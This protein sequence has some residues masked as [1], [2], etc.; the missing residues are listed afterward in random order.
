MDHYATQRRVSPSR[1][2]GGSTTHSSPRRGIHIDE[3]SRAATGVWYYRVD[4]AVYADHCAHS[5]NDD[6]N[7]HM[8]S[9]SEDSEF[10]GYASPKSFGAASELDV[11][12]QYYS[13]LRRYNDFL[14]LYDQVKVYV[15]TQEPVPEYLANHNS[16][17]GALPPFPEKEFLS[18]SVFGMLWRMSPSNHVLEDRRA[19]FQAFLQWVEQH[20]IARRAPAYAAFLG[21]PP[22]CQNGYVSLKEY[23]S[24]N[25]LSS[26]RQLAKDKQE[27]TRRYTMDAENLADL[28]ESTKPTGNAKTLRAVPETSAKPPHAAVYAFLGKRRRRARTNK[29]TSKPNATPQQPPLTTTELQHEHD[30]S[31]LAKRDIAQVGSNRPSLKKSKSF[32]HSLDAVLVSAS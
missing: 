7:H 25:W 13:V 24:P 11:H 20:P 31:A 26:L 12:S 16:N 28:L 6:S 2:S 15:A 29:N 8:H 14:H 21:R 22:Q 18:S 30:E 3:F 27:R 19:K 5:N 17:Q 32:H 1:S 4:I 10:S 9:G 23:T